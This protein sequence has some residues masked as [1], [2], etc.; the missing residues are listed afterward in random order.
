MKEYCYGPI[1]GVDDK[2]ATYLGWRASANALEPSWRVATLRG[3]YDE[4]HKDAPLDTSNPLK[5]AQTLAKFRRDIAQGNALT[6]SHFGSTLDIAYLQLRRSFT[7][8]ERFNR[9]N[10]ISAMF[11]S[12]VDRMVAADPSHTR[13]E[14]I[15]GFTENGQRRGGQFTFFETIYNALIDRHSYYLSLGT[16]KGKEQA[17][18][19][20]QIFNNW[21]ALT[22]FV[23]MKL[24]D[25]E[26]I[27]LGN[28]IDWAAEANPGNF[29]DN[30][31]EDI[32]DVSES[33]REHWQE[34]SDMRSSFG[35]LGSDVR[36]MIGYCP[37]YEEKNGERVIKLDDLG[38]PVRLDP[39]KV[40]QTL[41][42]DLRGCTTSAH[43]M[44]LF[45]TKE[46][47]LKHPWLTPI[48]EKLRK[49]P[50]LRTKFFC[51]FKKNFQPYSIL[52]EDKK[53]S[54]SHRTVYKTKIINKVENILSRVFR[55]NI[56]LGATELTENSLQDKS[57][58]VNWSNV[59]K[60]RKTVKEWLDPGPLKVA[61][62]WSPDTTRPERRKFLV[63]VSEALGLPIDADAIDSIMNSPKDLKNFIS[64]IKQAL[65]YGIEGNLIKED[66]SK[67]D[68]G[69]YSLGE[70]SYRELLNK[71]NSAKGSLQEKVDKLLLTVTRN[72]EGL[73][74]E[75]RARHKNAKGKK[76]TSYSD[77]NPSYM[78][79]KF[80]LIESYVKADDK[81]G[82]KQFIE[83]HYLKSSYFRDSN[84]N[85]LNR[86]LKELIDCCN[87]TVPLSE[88]VAADFSY[89]RDLG[90]ADVSFENFTSKKHI[91]DLLTRFFAD[92][93]ISDSANTAS[94]PVFVLGDSGASKFIRAK[95]Y[96]SREVLDDLFNVWRQEKRRILLMEAVN[97]DLESKGY[98]EIDNFSDR[99]VVV[100]R[101]S[102]RIKKVSG[103]YTLL[104]FL[105]NPKYAKLLGNETEAEVKA[106]IVA[107][108]KDAVADFKRN[109][110]EQGLLEKNS[111]GQFR[112]LPKNITPETLDRDLATYYW[113]SKDAIIQQL[114]LMTID[115]AFYK[116]TKDLQKRYKEIHAP[117]QI[118][119]LDAEDQYGA[120]YSDGIERCVYF[121]DISLDTEKTNPKLYAALVK[122][123][124]GNSEALEKYH[125]NTLTDG[126]GYRTLRS[127]R[128]VAA[129]AGL[130]TAKME[131]VYQEIERI[132]YAYKGTSIPAEELKRIAEYGVIFQPLKPFMFTHEEYELGNDRLFIPV[133]HKYAEAVL[134]PELLPEGS[135]LRDLAYYM[136]ENDIDVTASTKIVKVGCFG[137]TDISKATNAEELGAALSKGYVHKLSY[138]DYRIQTNVPY[139]E[140]D[141]RLFGTQTR[142]LCMNRVKLDSQDDGH[143][144]SYIDSEFINLGKGRE[145]SRMNG[146]NLITFYNSLIVQSILN[147]YKMFSD[148]INN[149]EEFAQQLIQSVIN[150]SRESMDNIFAYGLTDGKPTI[151]YFEA[152]LEHD[153][154]ATALSFFKRLVNKQLIQ[155][156]PL[157]QVSAMGIQDYSETGDLEIITDDDGNVTG[158]EC[159]IPWD[160]T[161][162]TKDA[163]GNTIK[164]ALDYDEFCNENGTLKT[165][166]D[167]VPLIEKVLPGSTQLVAYRI[168][169]ESDYSMMNL[170]VKRF[171]RPTA[172]GTIK[173]P[174]EGTTIAGFDFK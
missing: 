91:I 77:V 151:P 148:K 170:R 42:N 10:M 105:N 81:R 100:E 168:P 107:Y 130:W 136:E 171:S 21:G 20:R 22:S 90:T 110:Q 133:Q 68:A 74:L 87:G 112:F 149:P 7:A 118:L 8:E 153:S 28:N 66:I 79:D 41:M 5:A 69:D 162:T 25:T 14:Y 63:E 143:Y 144:A 54:D 109:L 29:G 80:T 85:I 6:M 132:K 131:R 157:V 125:K 96:S 89:Y 40:H 95:I 134:I 165:D 124:G 58:N 128:K 49:N 83:D 140:Q 71:E 102:G 122:K 34:T 108:M 152:G 15:N 48:V 65:T 35:S 39:V 117:G 155:G 167:G 98:K 73:R 60:F 30:I 120:K 55:T 156:M 92:K 56:A 23:R 172:G 93:Q 123:L 141:G 47:E 146:R 26:G 84:G 163:Q 154:S 38:I 46:G 61:K 161:Y 50:Q 37:V 9:I 174:V 127:Y 94:Y 67:L 99:N 169:T 12:L 72:K 2:I 164:V 147:S 138:S 142:K 114:Q 27:K 43:M 33:T 159:E 19:V 158:M 101:E 44:K 16:E 135:K 70:I 115:P 150:N 32:V 13:E 88:T 57:G 139:H 145:K 129:M 45:Y 11:S 3:M 86:W 75:S 78:G 82:L 64:N 116:N 53:Y 104:P 119:D 17:A 111:E 31:I 113:N 62:Y 106:A 18:K 97:E 76:V 160:L 1:T 173:V 59:Q 52:V 103:E 126:Q 166:P 121:D 51:D 36:R 24:R 4:M 137:S